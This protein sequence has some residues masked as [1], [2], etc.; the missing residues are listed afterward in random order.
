MGIFKKKSPEVLDLTEL[1][2]K[3][4]LE[5]SNELA[6]MEK[7]TANEKVV[8]L[9]SSS[10]NKGSETSFDLLNN[11]ASAASSNEGAAHGELKN[12]IEDIEYKLEKLIERLEHIENKLNDNK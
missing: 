5:R 6:K 9:T 11:L 1:Q 3:G 10:L 7:W 4:I 8:D 12:K 2:R